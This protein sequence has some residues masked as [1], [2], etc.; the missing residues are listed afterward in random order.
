MLLLPLA[1]EAD[2]DETRGN[3]VGRRE[4]KIGR[5]DGDD[6]RISRGTAS[7]QVGT[8]GGGN[9]QHHGPGVDGRSG[10]HGYLGQAVIVRVIGRAQAYAFRLA[11]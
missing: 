6:V 9:E 11:C 7:R 8:R 2:L 1:R 10:G 3:R 5:G 4:R